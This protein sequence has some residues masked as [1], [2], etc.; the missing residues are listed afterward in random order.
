MVLQDVAESGVAL[1]IE[2][3]RWGDTGGWEGWI[4]DSSGGKSGASIRFDAPAE[5]QVV[6]F[7]DKIQEV[8]I[9]ELW[10]AGRSSSWPECPI[11]SRHPLRPVVRESLAV[12]ECP[13]EA[14]TLFR[15]GQ[16]GKGPR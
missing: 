5:E 13:A 8:V 10:S 1:R 3:E 14:R 15:I 11:H 12:W 6:E 16:L 4:V 2:E 9:E 7:A